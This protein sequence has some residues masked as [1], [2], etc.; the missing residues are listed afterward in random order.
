MILRFLCEII[1]PI[2]G[3]LMDKMKRFIRKWCMYASMLSAP[4]AGFFF[5]R[6]MF[7]PPK[8]PVTNKTLE[9]LQKQVEETLRNIQLKKTG[10]QPQP[11]AP[12]KTPSQT[13]QAPQTAPARPSQPSI[14]VPGKTV[15]VGPE[16]PVVKPGVP[17][18][19][20]SPVRPKPQLPPRPTLSQESQGGTLLEFLQVSTDQEG[21]TKLKTIEQQ[22]AKVITAIYLSL[23]N[24][25]NSSQFQEA[26]DAV[27]QQGE[28]DILDPEKIAELNQ[29]AYNQIFKW[30]VRYY[31]AIRTLQ[32]ACG[33]ALRKLDEIIKAKASGKRL[34]DIMEMIPDSLRKPTD[35]EGIPQE[36]LI[37][38]IEQLKLD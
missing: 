20:A 13:S 23:A 33:P 36:Q 35:L 29:N 37:R 3:V 4:L 22:Y 2:R 27:A 1:E 10:Q 6:T 8:P 30:K 5:V 34:G 16:V 26:V 11:A 17:G 24:A 7:A 25:I 12:A 18:R 38:E 19:P 28:V 31:E 21:I 14:P 32:N 15:P 9:Q